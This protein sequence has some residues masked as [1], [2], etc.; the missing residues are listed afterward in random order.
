M[1]AQR[2]QRTPHLERRV[3]RMED[4]MH[5]VRQGRG[6]LRAARQ[7]A[8]AVGRSLAHRVL[9]RIQRADQAAQGF[10]RIGRRDL[11]RLFGPRRRSTR[12]AL[13]HPRDQ[14]EAYRDRGKNAMHSLDR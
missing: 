10:R 14:Q 2:L 12:H 1:L 5:L 8:Q 3:G 9:L 4:P 7:L 13:P 6:N 11:D